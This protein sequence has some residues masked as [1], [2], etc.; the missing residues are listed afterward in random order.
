MITFESASPGTSTP[1]QKLSVP[2]STLRGVDL[3]CSSN[4]LLGAP[5]PPVL[6]LN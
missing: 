6:R 1:P 5:P 3:N 4:L 2:K